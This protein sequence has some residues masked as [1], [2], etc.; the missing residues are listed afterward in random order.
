MV[1]PEVLAARLLAKSVVVDGGCRRWTGAHEHKGY[2]HI[3]V[4]PRL[5]P[6]H[7]VAYEIWI[8]PIPD[9]HEIDHV[10]A[11]GCRYRDCFEPAHLEAVTHAEN[12]RRANQARAARKAVTG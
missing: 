9:G 8:G 1:A 12:I 4:G 3:S 2:G 10:Y 5:R 7:V 11:S 6:V